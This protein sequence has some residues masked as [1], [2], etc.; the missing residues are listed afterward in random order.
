VAIRSGTAHVAC[1]GAN[2]VAFTG[3]PSRGDLFLDYQTT[4]PCTALS[5]AF[6]YR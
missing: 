5:V 6:G 3:E 1:D 4:D 2:H